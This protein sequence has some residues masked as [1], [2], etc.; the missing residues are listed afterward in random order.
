M[1][2][3][4]IIKDADFSENAID[5]ISGGYWLLGNDDIAASNTALNAE[6]TFWPSGEAVSALIRGKHVT[7][8]KFKC[9]AAGNYVIQH[10]TTMYASTATVTALATITCTASDVGNVVEADVDFVFP[11][12]GFLACYNDVAGVLSYLYDA[13]ITTAVTELNPV[14]TNVDAKIGK[15]RFYNN[16]FYISY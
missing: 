11:N 12:T 3:F 15:S 4:I 13:T 8:V 1:G 9:G 10:A 6:R 2:K 5:N 7:K 14:Y 16:D